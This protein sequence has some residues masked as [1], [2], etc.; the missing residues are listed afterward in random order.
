MKPSLYAQY[1]KERSYTGIVETK[2]GFATFE[3]VNQDVV[4]IKDL[5][6]IPKKRKKG[7]AA[8]FANKIVELAVADG[9]KLLLGSVDI[10]AKGAE[11]SVKVLTAYGMTQYKLDGTMIYFVKEIAPFEKKEEV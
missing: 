11:D 1:L 7:V 2:E 3:Y 8:G 5:Y 9:K 6:V 4:Y 10:Q